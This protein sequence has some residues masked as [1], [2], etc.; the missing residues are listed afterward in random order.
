MMKYLFLDLGLIEYSKAYSLQKYIWDLVYKNNHHGVIVLAEHHP[1]FTLGRSAKEQNVLVE[2]EKLKEERINVVNIERGG[3]VTYHGPGQ[4]VCYP[5]INLN[6][7]KKDIKS[8][9]Y[10]LEE[11]IIKFL[12]HFG[13]SGFRDASFTGVWTA[14]GKVASLGIAIRRWIAYHGVSINVNPQKKHL[15][16]IRP[17]GLENSVM[18]TMFDLIGAELFNFNLKPLL[19][20]SFTQVFN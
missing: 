16:Y 11:V 14:K 9:I 17:C 15:S 20:R 18:T 7:R 13:V 4:I 19:K 2:K 3:D 5:I 12:A 6:L 1:V 8:Y 10:D